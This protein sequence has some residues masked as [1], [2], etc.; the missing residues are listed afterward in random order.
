MILT[1]IYSLFLYNRIFFG[2]FDTNK[3]IRYYSDITRLEFFVLFILFIIIIFFGIFPNFL[4]NF[5]L[6]NL[7]RLLVIF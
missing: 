3:F 1:L 6:L 4:I 5:S 2:P 7:I